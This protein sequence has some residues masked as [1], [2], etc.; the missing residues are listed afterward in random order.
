MKNYEINLQ[1]FL[2]NKDNLEKLKADCQGLIGKTDQQNPDLYLP[3]WMHLMDTAGMMSYLI[4][5][6]LSHNLREFMQSE[7]IKDEVD[8]P[9]VRLWQIAILAAL[10]HDIGKASAAFQGRIASKIKSKEMVKINLPDFATADNAKDEMRNHAAIGRCILRISGFNRGFSSVCGAHHGK[11][12]AQVS[13]DYVVSLINKMQ[14]IRSLFGKKQFKSEWKEIWSSVVADC[15]ALCNLKEVQTIP[16]LSEAFWAILS[17]LVVEADWLASNIDYFPLISCSMSGEISDYPERWEKAWQKL[18]FPE[19]WHAPS[20]E[21]N[22]QIFGS[23]FGF[24]P[25]QLQS[26]LIKIAS[27]VS[28]PGLIIVEAQMGLGKTEAALAAAEIVSGTAG[29]GGIFYGLPTR[30]T[31]N[32]LFDRFSKWANEESVNQKSIFKLAHSTAHLNEEY[33]LLPKNTSQLN[34]DENST[35]LFV[36]DWMQKP[37][38]GILSDFVI[39]TV[40][41]GLMMALNHKHFMLKHLGMASKTIILDEVH[42]YDAY[43][44]VFFDAMLEWLGKYQVPAILLSATLPKTRKLKM[45]ESYLRGFNS[46][47]KSIGPKGGGVNE[48]VW[49]KVEGYPLITWMDEG[50]IYAQAVQEKSDL[51]SVTV[52]LKNYTDLATE[53]NEIEQITRKI[54]KYGG[55]EGIVVNTVR[56]SQE[57]AKYLNQKFPDLRIVL[58][59]S[60]FTDAQRADIEEKIQKLTGKKSTFKQRD[61]LV[62]IGTQVIEQS[63]DLDFDVLVTELAPMDL[64][65]QRMGRLHRHSNRENRPDCFKQPECYILNPNLDEIRRQS[66]PVYHPWYLHQTKKALPRRINIPDDIPGLVEKVYSEEIKPEDNKERLDKDQMEQAD[67]KKAGRAEAG[68][69]EPARGNKYPEIDGLMSGNA[70]TNEMQAVNSVREMGPS[71]DV[72][73]IQKDKNDHLFIS[74]PQDPMKKILLNLDQM[75]DFKTIQMILKQRVSIPV[76]GDMNK[77]ESWI[78]QFQLPYAEWKQSSLLK[79]QNFITLDADG[80]FYLDQEAYQYSS[81]LGLIKTEISSSCQKD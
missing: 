35:N 38:T 25:N 15:M 69:L 5:K 67:G 2:L 34:D 80:F 75:P 4:E 62:V 70:V 1:S 46:A 48:C 23:I 26:D 24:K 6:R 55:C 57:V 43:M 8:D 68:V 13:Q 45:L 71:I 42:A 50:H 44:N 7:L 37:K 36:H 40:D 74:D 47:H 51:K 3:L 41:Q 79:Y 53:L 72:I 17:G 18:N 9:E 29:M 16:S 52:Q 58:M 77:I 10:L 28:K 59:H 11:T 56:K 65:L 31:A 12:Q 27:G 19:I 81:E 66:H 76:Y 21:M 14:N 49:E 22:D 20:R 32:G 73:L 64:V 54:Q 30:A 60:R 78:E 39:G 33:N 63:L 61:K